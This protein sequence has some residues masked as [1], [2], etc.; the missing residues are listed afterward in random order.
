M[1]KT[2]KSMHFFKFSM[3]S[4]ESD[5]KNADKQ[6]F[7]NIDERNAVI[8]TLITDKLNGN[9]AMR[10]DRSSDYKDANDYAILEVITHDENFVFG[11]IGKEKDATSFQIRDKKTLL[12]H[13][14]DKK[15]DQ[16]FEAFSY[17]LIDR[18]N[19][20]VTYLQEPSAPSILFL[21][22]AMS[23]VRSSS[24]KVWGS[25]SALIA[26][27]A[28]PF[29]SGK[30]TIGSISYSMTL[31]A[32][33]AR[34]ITG[35]SEKDYELLLN[36]GSMEVTVKFKAKKRNTSVFAGADQAKEFLT[37]LL[38]GKKKVQ[39]NAKNED[40][41]I[42]QNYSLVNNALV[43]RT[44]FTFDSSLSNIKDIQANIESKMKESY[45]INK[46]DVKKY[47]GFSHKQKES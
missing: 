39:V 43:K 22:E 41:S 37:N 13:P 14:I 34:E 24:D 46:S 33:S 26:R 5:G 30:D 16:I 4:L 2:Y 28:L 19:F 29:I 6:R 7:L 18:E 31:P 44:D 12:A 3:Y 35:L 9:N 27:D 36:Q 32:G 47:I 8:D 10:V 1:A 42:A 25:V 17:F 38:P 11:R 23:Y 15:I 45:L 40:D 20:A 21:G